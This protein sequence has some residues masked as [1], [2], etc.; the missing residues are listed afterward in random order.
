MGP[1]RPVLCANV[2]QL[3][4][5]PFS[6]TARDSRQTCCPVLSPITGGDHL[7]RALRRAQKRAST[8]AEERRDGRK[9]AA[10]SVVSVGGGARGDYLKLRLLLICV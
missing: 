7:L 6:C 8:S 1:A 10:T 3:A 9:R 2:L 4:I 5:R